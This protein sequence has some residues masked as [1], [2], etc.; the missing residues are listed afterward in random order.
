MKTRFS[1]SRT[2]ALA[3]MVVSA[4]A[5]GQEYPSKP[6]R[7]IVGFA[8]GGTMDVIGRLMQNPLQ[9]RLKVPIVIDNR[10]GAGGLIGANIAAKAEPDG[11]TITHI[12]MSTVSK[13]LLKD[14]PVDFYKALVPV[15]SL[16]VSPF[17]LQINASLPV[18]TA[19]EFVAYVKANPGKLNVG[20]TNPVSMLPMTLFA[21]VAGLQVQ[22]IE[23]KS[24]PALQTAVMTNEIQAT[25]GTAQP[26]LPHANSAKVKLL[27]VTGDQR[28]PLLPNVPTT[29]E[30]GFPDVNALVIGGIM[31]PAGTPNAA[32]A[33]L[34]AAFRQVVSLPEV[35]K[36]F[37]NNGRALNVSLEEMTR[38]LKE[39]EAMWANV[40]K[41]AGFKPM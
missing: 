10:P 17:L 21:A 24:S 34:N 1:L 9:E 19:K 2:A 14:Q 26:V 38:M 37:A 33:K 5:F 36:H 40:A 41:V 28:L 13:V 6:V 29:A 35:E 25:F 31:A 4:S 8:P 18:S 20:A 15:A 7:M 16:W 12:A 22:P 11:Y 23:Y 27:M 32:I 39:E 3:A 30:A